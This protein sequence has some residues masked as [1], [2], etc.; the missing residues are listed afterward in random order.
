[1][2]KEGI[3]ID[4]E[5]YMRRDPVT[6]QEKIFF[7]KRHDIVRSPKLLKYDAC[8]SERLRGKRYRGHGAQADTEAVR[9]ALR[10]AAHYCAQHDTV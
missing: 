2:A 4:L 7:R 5:P 8:M 10:E 9:E 6:G 3:P 1:M